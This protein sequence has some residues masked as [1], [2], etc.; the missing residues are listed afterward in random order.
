M[1]PQ[2]IQVEGITLNTRVTIHPYYFQNF[3]FRMAMLLIRGNKVLSEVCVTSV[4]CL[5]SMMTS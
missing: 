3:E 4:L 5:W 2:S 1:D